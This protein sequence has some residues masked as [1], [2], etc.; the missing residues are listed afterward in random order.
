MDIIEV[1]LYYNQIFFLLPENITQDCINSLS[2]YNSLGYLEAMN[3]IQINENP[4]SNK[5]I[6]KYLSDCSVYLNGFL[7]L[8]G[9]GKYIN[10]FVRTEK[11]FRKKNKKTKN[12]T[13]KKNHKKTTIKKL[14]KPK[15][16]TKRL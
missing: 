7:N 8:S 5:N 9:G 14:H 11:K 16:F 13:N 2:I 4:N 10:K 3:N 1:K 6:N 15:K 12:N